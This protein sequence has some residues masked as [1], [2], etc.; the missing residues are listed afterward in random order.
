MGVEAVQNSH[1]KRSDQF[2]G[3]IAGKSVF[4]QGL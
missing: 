2:A 1:S 3:R 4:E